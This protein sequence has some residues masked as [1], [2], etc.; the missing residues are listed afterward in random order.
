MQGGHGRRKKIP[1][2][3]TLAAHSFPSVKI[4]IPCKFP[5]FTFKPVIPFSGC[6]RTKSFT[7]KK[8]E[9]SFHFSI[10]AMFAGMF[11]GIFTFVFI[12]TS[13]FISKFLLSKTLALFS[14]AGLLL[15]FRFY[16]KWFGLGKVEATLFNIMA[17]GP[18]I[19]SLLLWTN[20]LVTTGEKEETIPVLSARITTAVYFD[21]LS[22]RFTL[23][24]KA[25]E[26]YPEFRTV[27]L[28]KGN[29]EIAGAKQLKI[30]TA[31]GLLGYK[32]F[33]GNEAVGE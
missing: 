25:Y 9:S 17:I 11:F 23:E 22:V 6:M 19:S 27:Q 4:H 8:P 18:T 24:N 3:Y 7:E 29:L 32:V 26:E 1:G 14:F 12:G 28:E 16:K 20:F 10:A 33:L 2:N 13:T 5:T 30:K 15:P 31:E 21:D